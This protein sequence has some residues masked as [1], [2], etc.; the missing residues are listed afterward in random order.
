MFSDGLT[1]SLPPVTQNW[2]NFASFG[3]LL[4]RWSRRRVD[5]RREVVASFI[6]S[7]TANSD[8]ARPSL[9]FMHVLLP[10][11]PWLYLPS[12]QRFTLRRHMI[13]LRP[14][15]TW[16]DGEWAA[17]LNYQRHLLQV[18][19]ADSVLGTLMER[20]RTVG[21]YDDALIVVTSDHGANFR[22]GLSFRQPTVASFADI[23]SVPLFI[24]RSGQRNG[25]IVTANIESIDIV[26]TLA[27]ELGVR[28]PWDAD[29][30][31]VFA[32]TRTSRPTKIMFFDGSRRKL[33]VPGDL[34]DALA[35]GV[36]RKF[37][38]F[39]T[40]DPIN[41]PSLGVYG[42][43]VGKAAADF[44]VRRSGNIEVVIDAL[45]LLGDVDHG[46]DFVPAHITGAVV[47]RRDARVTTPLAI[48]INGVLAAVTRV[49]TF[50]VGGRRN[51][52]EAIVDP[53][54]LA[55]GAN[56]IEVFVV[57]EGSDGTVVLE[58]T[59]T[60]NTDPPRA[61]VAREEASEL[62]GVTSSGFYQ[63]EWVA[64]RAFRWTNGAAHLSVPTDPQDPPSQ[65]A[66]EVLMTG[67]KPKHLQIVVNGCTLFDATI[68]S[69]WVQ[70]LALDGC[71]VESASIE[72]DLLTGVHTQTHDS[73][74]L[75]VGIASVELYGGKPLQIIR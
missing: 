10:H 70:T 73:R 1:A 3:N 65:M 37:E 68:W 32:P 34:N 29:G 69:I 2:K 21:V 54:L 26:P 43:L 71:P 74:T 50:P 5:D 66:V 13:C 33:V 53:S 28:P 31:N 30:L 46:A 24:K 19:Y 27:A 61:N 7:I 25:S 15:G 20:L 49:Y 52:W 67:P 17:A 11:E 72:I 62:W 23:A 47:D 41:Q 38:L 44:Q 8:S 63:T 40:G 56:T 60:D 4:G 14:D 16:V 36:A 51:M 35:A 58:E 75:G 45:D 57:R 18:K 12:G 39:A 9:Y 59:Y 6:G 22:P 55:Q 42:E 64:H 48:A